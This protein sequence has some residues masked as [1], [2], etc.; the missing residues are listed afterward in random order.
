M[1]DSAQ[2][3]DRL[4][5]KRLDIIPSERLLDVVI[6][7]GGP[8]G[9]STALS[10][11]RAGRSVTILERSHYESSRVG[12][13]LPPEVRR[14]LT[15]LGLWERFRAEGHLASPGIASAWGR[16]KLYDNDFIVNPQGSGWHVDRRRFDVML[17]QAAAEAG[18]EVLRGARLMSVARDSSAGWRLEAQVDERRWE[19]RAAILV[20][21]SGRSASPA[22]RLGGHRI[23][24]DRL[25]GLVGL[26][27]PD[28]A[29]PNRDRRTLIE[30]VETGWWYTAPLPDGRRI[31]V[32]LTDADLL[33]AGRVARARTWRQQLG[34]APHTRSRLVPDTPG[35]EPWIVPARTARLER[36][37]SAGW[38]AVG[39]AACSF[40]PLSSQGVTSALESG[41]AAARALDASFRGDRRALDDYA[42]RVEA[43][44]RD[45]L[46]SRADY[47]GR[48]RRWPGS[49][50]WRRRH[51][52]PADGFQ[53][54]LLPRPV[55]R[56]AR[57][58]GPSGRASVVPD[59]RHT[60]PTQAGREQTLAFGLSG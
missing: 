49:P 13:T 52:T 14:P 12:E 55:V 20:D 5:S 35:V 4:S 41:L 21:A 19:T 42:D 3:A 32:F 56:G 46:H 8:A 44:F 9:T 30:A 53:H 23:T 29:S 17:A 25:V 27:P 58:G 59:S 39:D 6:V 1:N 48:E 45:Y 7:G 54:D 16:P 34:R 43:E 57:N 36:V 2:K 60:H 37:T 24:Y 26:V 22:R 33:S 11:A 40:D 10:L 38:L 15:E 18:V 28:P 47:Y 50:F 31:A 51:N